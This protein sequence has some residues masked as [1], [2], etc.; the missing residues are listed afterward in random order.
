[1]DNQKYLKNV[2]TLQYDSSK[3][4]GCKMC[5][6]VCPHNVFKMTGKKAE[7]INKDRCMECGACEINCIAN[8][9]SVKQ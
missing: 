7:I 4:I 2:A 3:C 6:E 5:M 8:S 1:M 9:L